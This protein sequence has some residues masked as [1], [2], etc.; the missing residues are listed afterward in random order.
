MVLPLAE[1]HL[2]SIKIELRRELC[3]YIPQSY[4][5]ANQLVL[6]H[7]AVSSM[8]CCHP[9]VWFSDKLVDSFEGT[10]PS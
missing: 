5:A 9:P 1:H 8:G 3:A 2:G 6:K 10:S 4:R 7:L